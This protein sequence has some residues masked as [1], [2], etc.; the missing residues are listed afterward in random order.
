METNSRR[1]TICA[2]TKVT[3]CLFHIRGSGRVWHLIHQ[4]LPNSLEAWDKWVSLETG[5]HR[6]FQALGVGESFIRT[7][8]EVFWPYSVH[9]AWSVPCGQAPWQLLWGDV[10]NM[11]SSSHV[12]PS[13]SNLQAG[14]IPTYLPCASDPS[15]FRKQSHW[16][17]CDAFSQWLCWLSCQEQGGIGIMCHN[18]STGESSKVCSSTAQGLTRQKPFGQ[19]ACH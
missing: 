2:R 6:K 7:H 18:S 16:I 8:R 12:K 14:Y 13:S 19:H 17:R 1:I 11:A 10:G 5:G 15:R 4:L 3:E 9:T